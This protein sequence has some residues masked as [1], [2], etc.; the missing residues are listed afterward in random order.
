MNGT[1]KRWAGWMASVAVWAV[2]GV[3]VAMLG[4]AGCASIEKGQDA[5]VVNA[6]RTTAL[7]LE[8]FDAFLQWEFENRAALAVVPEIRKTADTIRRGGI[9]WLQ[10]A[11]AM[12]KAYKA[13]R[14]PENKANLETALEVLRAAVREA[15]SYLNTPVASAEAEGWPAWRAA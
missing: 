9:T 4:G 7:A 8:V 15:Q 3:T 1:T 12:T 6:E 2:L 10:S 11:R 14:T 13:N 5:V